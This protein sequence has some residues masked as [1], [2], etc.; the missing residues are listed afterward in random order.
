MTDTAMKAADYV[1][2]GVLY[3]REGRYLDAHTNLRHALVGFGKLSLKDVPFMLLSY[4]GLC[5]VAL[6]KDTGR[7]LAY[8]RR[9]VDEAGN[10]S[11]YYF[12]LGKALVFLKRKAEA[13]TA[14]QHGLAIDDDPRIETELNRLG[15]RSR[16]AIPFLPRRHFLN[17][18]LGRLVRRPS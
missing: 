12:N 6:G 17:R 5:L 13:I 3:A 16:P 15:I 4:Y 18:Y 11:E 2:L 10:R 1:E 14:F 8:C 7:G 9:A